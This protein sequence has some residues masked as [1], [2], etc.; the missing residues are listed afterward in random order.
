ML[1]GVACVAVDPGA[2]EAVMV[3]SKGSVT[4]DSRFDAGYFVTV[5]VGKQE[6]QGMLYYPPAEQT[7]V[8]HN[9]LTP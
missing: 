7:Q 3:G 6:F 5:R 2:S 1:S 8:K 4:V 9:T